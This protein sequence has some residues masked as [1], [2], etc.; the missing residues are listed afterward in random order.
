MEGGENDAGGGRL[1]P[2]TPFDLERTNCCV[3]SLLSLSGVGR[4]LRQEVLLRAPFV[5]A[6]SSESA[7]L[8]TTPVNDA[9]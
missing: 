6:L 8:A 4:A 3:S 2:M 9:V 5:V 7:P 1:N